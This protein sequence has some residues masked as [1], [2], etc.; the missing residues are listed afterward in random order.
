MLSKYYYPKEE[1]ADETEADMEGFLSAL[2]CILKGKYGQ[3]DIHRT[4]PGGTLGIFFELDIDGKRKFV[5]THQPGNSHREN[6]MNESDIMFLLY[7]DV[8]GFER[9]DVTVCG[10]TATFMI[11]DYLLPMSCPLG[12]WQIRER[13]AGYLIKI[14]VGGTRV[15]YTFRNILEAGRESLEILYKKGF[16]EEPVYESCKK[17][18]VYVAEQYSRLK[19]AVCHGDLS[20]VNIMLAPD[21]TPVIIDWEDALLA[22][23]EYDFLYWL[24]FFS[25]RKYYSPE[26][27]AQFGIER[28]LGVGVMVLIIIIKSEMSRRNGDYKRNSLSFQRRIEEVFDML[29]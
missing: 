27:F 22:F 19:P 14:P 11:M 13:I 5:K 28:E 4:H 2:L 23:E 25:Q 15:K 9:I 12:L 16:L 3:V 26:L 17:S 29:E 1:R 8:I 24:T 21:G 6:L 18:T 10:K 7:Q 20:N